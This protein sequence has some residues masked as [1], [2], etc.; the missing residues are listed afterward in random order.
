MQQRVAIARALVYSPDTL[1]M[2]EPFGA[3]DEITRD[4][5]RFELLR[6]W[7]HATKTVLFVTH[8]ITEAIILSDEVVVMARQ[9]GRIRETVPIALPRP[10][11]EAMER[12]A[13]FQEYAGY[14]KSL[15]R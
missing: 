3:L 1:L 5:M 13:Q 7:E 2:D 14:L 11:D 10:R 8:S 15:L 9:P 6:I 4:A 12:G